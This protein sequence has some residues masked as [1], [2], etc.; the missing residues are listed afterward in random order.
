MLQRVREGSPLLLR[1]LGRLGRG[2]RLRRQPDRLVGRGGHEP[3][4][5]RVGDRHGDDEDNVGRGEDRL[6]ERHPAGQLLQGVTS[7]VEGR[8]DRGRQAARP[9]RVA[10]VRRRGEQREV[11]ARQPPADLAGQDDPGHEADAPVQHRDQRGEQAHEQGRLRGRPGHLR[12]AGEDPR[13]GRGV[14][15]RLR[16]DDDDRQLHGEPDQAPQ[17]SPKYFIICAGVVGVARTP[18][19]KMT[20]IRTAPITYGSG[21]KR[22]TNELVASAIRRMEP[23]QVG[24]TL[25]VDMVAPWV[26]VSRRGRRS[27]RSR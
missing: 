19:R 1:L 25:V 3:G 6:G 9:H 5:E 15:Q 11:R 23:R 21:R 2:L 20:A 7:G 12:H 26:I 14:D 18:H 24:A 27:R 16:C 10:G 22:W 4:D 8:R 17:P 13:H